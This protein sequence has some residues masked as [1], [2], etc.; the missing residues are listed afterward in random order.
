MSNRHTREIRISMTRAFETETG[1]MSTNPSP[2]RRGFRARHQYNGGQTTFVYS[3]DDTQKEKTVSGTP[4]SEGPDEINRE[5][6]EQLL[7][8][9]DSDREKAGAKYEAI[10]KRLIKFFVCRGCNVGEDLTDKTVN[11]VARKLPE[12]R[13]TYD[14]EPGHYFHGVAKNIY[15]EWLRQEQLPAVLPPPPAPPEEDENKERMDRCLQRCMA[16]LSAEDRQL[17]LAYYEQEKHAKI[18]QRK[19]LAEQL[20]VGMNALRLRLYRIRETLQECVEQCCRDAMKL[21]EGGQH[22]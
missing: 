5:K 12:F 4:S 14:G 15:H 6:F 19:K 11:R 2:K 9:L 7:L 8:W 22:S 21:N 10:R 1:A 17:V 16:R 3:R 13:D 18:D 20:G